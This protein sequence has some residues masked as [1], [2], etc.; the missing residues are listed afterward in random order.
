MI[1]Q[2]LFG[3][4]I[5]FSKEGNSLH[6]IF[7]FYNYVLQQQEFE[8]YATTHTPSPAA[9]SFITFRNNSSLLYWCSE[10]GNPNITFHF[11]YP[12]LITAYSIENA[13]NNGN[14]HTY[15][16]KIALYGS[17]DNI[18]WDV[19]DSP[20]EEL[21]FCETSAC[22]STTVL[23][24]SVAY[25]NYYSFIRLTS[26]KNS[27]N[28]DYLILSSLEFFGEIKFAPSCTHLSSFRPFRR[29]IYFIVCF[30]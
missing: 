18:T 5:P 21:S 15:P 28:Y 24:F 11:K 23:S 10:S 16:Q 25:P 17:N 4:Y 27:Q 29:I 12:I 6:G 14:E 26:L 20:A 3:K 7:N 9:P 8:I 1:Y 30:S 22:P 13:R 2:K 19:I